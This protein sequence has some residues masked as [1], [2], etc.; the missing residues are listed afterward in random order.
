MTHPWNACRFGAG[1][2]PFRAGDY[3]RC[4]TTSPASIYHAFHGCV[5]SPATAKLSVL[6]TTIFFLKAEQIKRVEIAEVRRSGKRPREAHTSMI[7]SADG[8]T[9]VEDKLGDFRR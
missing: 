7:R 8:N 1:V 9:E 3:A 2:C 4:I 5:M 6:I